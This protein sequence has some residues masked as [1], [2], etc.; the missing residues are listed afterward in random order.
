MMDQQNQIQLI[1]MDIW[2]KIDNLV[3]PGLGV[4]WTVYLEI[5][6]ILH[7]I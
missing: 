6:Y 5:V 1:E 4:I 7:I 2:N 3:M